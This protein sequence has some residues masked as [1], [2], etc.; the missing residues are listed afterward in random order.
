MKRILC[1]IVIALLCM[2]TVAQGYSFAD[3]AVI[4]FGVVHYSD[5]PM[6]WII[7]VPDNAVRVEVGIYG[8]GQ[9][10]VNKYGGWNGY[11]KLNGSYIWRMTGLDSSGVAIIEDSALGRTV[12]ELS[13]RNAWIDITGM[14]SPG[15]NTLTYYHYT[16][17]PG[18]GVKV[19]MATSDEPVYQAEEGT[20]NVSSQAVYDIEITNVD[21]TYF[22]TIFTGTITQ[23]GQPVGHAQLGVE[24]PFKGMSLMGPTTDGNGN[25]TYATNPRS[26]YWDTD[27]FLFTYGDA[28]EPYIVSQIF[29]SYEQV[30]YKLEDNDVYAN[31]TDSR[32]ENLFVYQQIEN[33]TLTNSTMSG[34]D[35][36]IAKQDMMDIMIDGSLTDYVSTGMDIADWAGSVGM[37]AKGV[38]AAG[39]TGGSTAA[40]GCAPLGVKLVNE[41]VDVST[42]ILVDYGY[43]SGS[44]ANLIDEASSTVT[45]CI[46]VTDPIDTASCLGAIAS[47]TLHVVSYELEHNDYGQ[48]AVVVKVSKTLSGTVDYALVIIDTLN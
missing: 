40:V 43:I 10:Q 46:S 27:A 39:V 7:D 32:K 31:L 22:S 42:D 2:S 30:V 9:S 5:A 15:E 17:G 35:Y 19:R 12:D 28:A 24:D 23:N 20:E 29:S 14:V 34:Y 37:C 44:S 4:D 21:L 41:G 1:G 33:G 16:G 26:S 36:N 25:F 47:G 11:M 6:T 13:G 18:A 48:P 38:A 8:S 45:S 3:E